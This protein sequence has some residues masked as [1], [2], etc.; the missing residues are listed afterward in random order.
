MKEDEVDGT[1]DSLE[2]HENCYKICVGKTEGKQPLKDLG[3]DGRITLESVLE[4]QD[5]EVWTG[6]N[7][8]RIETNG[9][10]L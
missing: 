10:S 2:R 5:G 4:K 9:G 6:F 1:H 3:V 8:I 7:W